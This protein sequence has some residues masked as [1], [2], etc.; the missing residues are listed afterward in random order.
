M[1]V[2][3]IPSLAESL[4]VNRIVDGIAVTHPMGAPEL[5]AV[6]EEIRRVQL[7]DLALDAL[8]TSV[9]GPTVFNLDSSN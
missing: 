4:G 9:D 6:E 3:A 5:S 1:L 2:T 7:F 8:K